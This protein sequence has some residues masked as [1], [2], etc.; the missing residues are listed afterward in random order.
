MATNYL[1]PPKSL[2][3]QMHYFLLGD[4]DL[5]PSLNTEFAGLNPNEYLIR[6]NLNSLQFISAYIYNPGTGNPEQ[7]YDAYNINLGDWL[8]NDATGFTWK[9]SAIYNVTDAPVSGNNTGA[10][11]FYAKMTD[12]DYF[13][14]GLDATGL[15][16]GAPVFV[17]SRTILFTVDEDGFP[18]FT[19]SD[20]FNLSANFS[21]NVIGRFRALNTYNQ[22]VSIYQPGH[23]LAVGDPVYIDSG[24]LFQKSYGQGD[25]SGVSFT[26]GIVTSV[27]VPDSNYF[28]FNPFGE[29]RKYTDISVTGPAG[30]LFYISPTGA[31]PYTGDRPALYPYPVY[32]SIDASGN[33]I[34]LKGQG[35]G[36]VGGGG[37]SG[38]GP[39]GPTGYV[40]VDGATGATGPTGQRGDRYATQTT[41][42]ITPTVT[43]G[44]SQSLTVGTGLAYLAG[45]S[46]I[47][48]SSSTPSIS[49]E[50]R[51]SS[52]N[53][54]SGA[55]V[56]NQA[57]N[58]K[59]SFILDT[60]TVNL[61]GI[62]G[63]TGPTGSKGDTGS[64]GP[65]GDRFLSATTSPVLPTPTEGG[66]QSLTIGTQLSY[67]PG[68]SVVVV[69]SSSPSVSFEGRVASYN[70]ASGALVVD[71]ITNIK[72]SFTSAVYNV[73]LDGVDGPTGPTGPTGATGAT[74]ATGP[75][76]WT[77]WTGP[78][79]PTGMTGSTG[80]TGDTG[81]TGP[82]GTTGP[83]GP[84][85][86]YIFDGGSAYSTY[87]LGPAFDCGSSV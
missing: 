34:L 50:A 10:G 38:T 33:A 41:S 58:I 67:I 80:P 66:S 84:V 69:N 78:T 51:V 12:V 86:Y 19:P 52:Y 24:G 21:G 25:V 49:F 62:D 15:A 2:D 26:I 36:G 6:G 45:N 8:A 75:T 57:T 5:P 23:G 39:T 61:D 27:D 32:Q 22:Y 35:F 60:Y 56:L 40:G 48:V 73:N 11:V 64:T 18:I 70:S 53:S 46:V 79:G 47:V 82:T 20:T 31:A 54:G 1:P 76:G 71:Q 16:N 13:N 81:S 72:G 43:E 28:T 68:N 83:T 77:G 3:I 29:Y 17:D 74:G 65:T 59:G 63:P 42:A 4:T 55:M 30:S 85:S 14:A 44:G 7:Y 9:I 87:F 37:G